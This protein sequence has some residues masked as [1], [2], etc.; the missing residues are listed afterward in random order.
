MKRFVQN[1]FEILAG[2][3]EIVFLD[4]RTWGIGW[5]MVAI[6]ALAVILIVLA[7]TAAEALGGL[8]STLIEWGFPG[9]A[10]GLAL[11]IWVLVRLHRRR[12]SEPAEEIRDLLILDLR[13]DALR[14]RMGEVLAQSDELRARMHIDWWTR[15]AMRVVVLHWPGG[16]RT[17]Y[18]SF[19]RQRSLEVLAFLR[20]QGLDAV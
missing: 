16:R 2:E 14:N 4:R 12:R 15:G 3:H 13:S 10:A 6:G 7:V 8:P 17:I 18:R 20:E 9:A 19:G 1:G 5:A 11:G